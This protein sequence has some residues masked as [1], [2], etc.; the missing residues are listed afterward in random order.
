M[1]RPSKNFSVE[2]NSSH[3]IKSA[4]GN[5]RRLN[6][7]LKIE[8]TAHSL[9]GYYLPLIV[10][11]ILCLK[12]NGLVMEKLDKTKRVPFSSIATLVEEIQSLPVEGSLPILGVYDYKDNADTRLRYLRRLGPVI[13]LSEY[14]TRNIEK[15]YDLLLPN[16]EPFKTVFVHGDLQSR[17]FAEKNGSLAIFDFDNSHFGCELEDWAFLSIRHP[18]YSKD[19]RNYLENKYSKDNETLVRFDAAFLLMQIDKFLNGYFSRTY[20]WRG[21]PFDVAAKAYGRARLF[22][23]TRGALDLTEHL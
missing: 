23:L 10:P 15:T 6:E 13:G 8:R 22:S 21:R 9:L 19:V 5:S 17:H 1:E 11:E 7:R 18:R 4:S 16:L 3:V 2:V 20:Q 14:E 12:S